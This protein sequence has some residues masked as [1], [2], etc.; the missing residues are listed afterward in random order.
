MLA[1]PRSAQSR[2]TGCQRGLCYR[3]PPLGATRS[4]APAVMLQCCWFQGCWGLLL[5]PL[6][7]PTARFIAVHWTTGLIPDKRLDLS[8]RESTGKPREQYKAAQRD[9][10]HCLGITLRKARGGGRT[11][12]KGKR[13]PGARFPCTVVSPWE[14]PAT[15]Q[16][17]LARMLKVKSKSHSCLGGLWGEEDGL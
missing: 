15:S 8:R 11:R 4:S 16:A 9:R 2:T 12:G 7:A 13:N 10:M 5:I 1:C 3:P 14:I 6:P 17:L